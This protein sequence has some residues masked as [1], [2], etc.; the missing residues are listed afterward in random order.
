MCVL[1]IADI[2]ED[3]VLTNLPV[4][5]PVN[6]NVVVGTSVYTVSVLDN[7]AGQTQMFTLQPNSYFQM[8]DPSCKKLRTVV[9]RLFV[10]VLRF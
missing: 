2:N 7:D 8:L 9:V 4:S 10:I 5:V 3:P 1:I 6:E